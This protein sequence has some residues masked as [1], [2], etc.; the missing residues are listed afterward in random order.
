MQ[1]RTEKAEIQG[2]ESEPGATSDREG[3]NTG[4]RV[5]TRCNFGQRK[6][7]YELLSP[8]PD[9]LESPRTEDHKPEG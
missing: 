5:R 2:L 6:Q 3:R 8:N 4:F 7:K 9:Y 1:L